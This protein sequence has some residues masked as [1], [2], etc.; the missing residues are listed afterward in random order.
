MWRNQ[1]LNLQVYVQSRNCDGVFVL[2]AVQLQK[3]TGETGEDDPY[4]VDRM[5]HR[6]GRQKQ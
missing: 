1:K 4:L 6:V 5:I 2:S 3:N